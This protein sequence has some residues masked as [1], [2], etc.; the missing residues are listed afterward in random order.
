MEGS[1]PPEVA[2]GTRASSAAFDDQIHEAL[3]EG[4]SMVKSDFSLKATLAQQKSTAPETSEG[5]KRAANENTQTLASPGQDDPGEADDDYAESKNA[6]KTL[7][8]EESWHVL[9]IAHSDTVR[10]P[11]RP[12]DEKAIAEQS[13]S[14]EEIRPGEA[15]KEEQEEEVWHHLSIAHSEGVEMAIASQGEL[16]QQPPK[17]W[18]APFIARSEGA[19]KAKTVESEPASRRA[20]VRRRQTANRRLG[21]QRRSE[22]S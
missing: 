18:R 1:A 10:T 9:P 17:V 14:Q 15:D 4:K 13:D 3:Q 2:Q 7:P 5:R 12:Q 6:E 22:G 16:Q 11:S 8:D 20:A 19:E 21:R